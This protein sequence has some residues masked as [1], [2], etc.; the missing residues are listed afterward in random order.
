MALGG[1][2]TG[3]MNTSEVATVPA[4]IT[5]KGSKRM[6]I[7]AA[8]RI[9]MSMVVVAV[10]EVISDRNLA[11]RITAERIRMVGSDFNSIRCMAMY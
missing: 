7:P 3:S 4:I 1:V 6:A 9:G 2:A 5:L 10:L 8:K 11:S